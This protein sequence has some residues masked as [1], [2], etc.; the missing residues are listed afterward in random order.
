MC[1]AMVSGIV[2]G[3]TLISYW[4]VFPLSPVTE[5]VPEVFANVIST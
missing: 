4:P 5:A 3:A 2:T 1:P